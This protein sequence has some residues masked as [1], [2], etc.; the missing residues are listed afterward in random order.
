MPTPFDFSA[1]LAPGGAQVAPGW[2][3]DWA[4]F[5]NVLQ[6]NIDEAGNRTPSDVAFGQDNTLMRGADPYY[7][8]LAS[9]NA[10]ILQND[11]MS[12]IGQVFNDVQSRPFGPVGML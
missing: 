12:D 5:G 10:G 4:A 3:N 11:L 6:P 2:I 9:G 7:F 8:K 1:G